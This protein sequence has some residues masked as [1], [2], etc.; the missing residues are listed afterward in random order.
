L[1]SL[2]AICRERGQRG[3]VRLWGCHLQE[4]DIPPELKAW[5]ELCPHADEAKVIEEL[6]QCRF[7]YAMY[8]FTPRLRRFANT[9][10]P[11]KLSS[12]VLAQRPILAHG[13][14]SSSLA[15]F[16]HKTSLGVLWDNMDLTCG[17]R[18]VT[19]LCGTLVKPQAWEHARAAYFGASN[20]EILKSTFSRLAI[21]ATRD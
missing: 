6:Q 11:T 13:P 4:R 17:Q 8:P 1:K 2:Q 3:R 19:A 21:T 10:L 12:Y 20:V 15:E 16:L 14:S 7:V 5:I 18:V 9:S